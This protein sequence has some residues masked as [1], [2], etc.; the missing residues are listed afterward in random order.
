MT[1]IIIIKSDGDAAKERSSAASEV[2]NRLFSNRRSSI[3][4][5]AELYHGA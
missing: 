3:E 5:G 2:K 1:V 4:G